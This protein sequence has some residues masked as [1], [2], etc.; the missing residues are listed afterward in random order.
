MHVQSINLQKC[1]LDFSKAFFLHCSVFSEVA[2]FYMVSCGSELQ[3]D[4]NTVKDLKIFLLPH[5]STSRTSSGLPRSH[6]FLIT[7]SSFASR[8]KAVTLDNQSS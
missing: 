1:C 7:F 4:V 5:E 8:K 6:L 3:H 2:N